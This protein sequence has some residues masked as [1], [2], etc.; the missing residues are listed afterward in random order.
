MAAAD[1]TALSLDQLLELTVVG[2]SKF[3]Q[4]QSEVAA[5]VSVI[6][7]QEIKAF[8]WRTIGEAL[9]SL[10]GI[11]T[12]YDRQYSYLGMR[13]FGLPGDYNTRVLVTVNGNRVNDA[14][15]DTGPSGRQFPVDID[16]IE[17]IEFIPGPGGAVY[18]Q[19][20]ML[21]VVNVVTRTGAGVD[22]AEL[23]A[24]HQQPQALSAGRATWGKLLDDGTDVLLS[25]SALHAHG[26]DRFLDFGASGVSG[27]AAGLDG[28]RSNQVLAH[29]AHGAW[30]LDLEHGDR[31]KGDPTGVYLSDPLVPGQ[32][33]QDR[34]EL[35][36]LQFQDS[37]AADTVHVAARLFEGQLR[38]SSI[39]SQAG[40]RFSYPASSDW[41]GAELRLRYTASARHKLMVGVEAQDNFNQDQAALDLGN[42]ANDIVIPGSGHRV[43][44]YVQDDWRISDTLAST[45]GLRMD[46]NNVTGA[47]LSPR[48][49]L[50]WQAAPATALK[51]LYGRAS[52]A[53]NNYECCY[54]GDGTGQVANPS[55]KGESIDTLELVVDH[56]VDRDLALRASIYR[57][58]ML[59]L[60]T[61]QPTD[62]SSA[63]S[64][65]QYQ[66]GAT[67][68]AQGVELSAD[69]TWASGARL[70]GS[71]SFQDAAS[72]DGSHLLNS[73]R[74]LGK[75]ELSGPLPLAGLR[76][77]Y[78]LRYDGPRLSR[79]GSTL[80]GYVLSNLTLSTEQLARGLEISFS[81]FNLFDEHYAQPAAAINWQNA[82][83][84]DGRSM[85]VQLVYR[86]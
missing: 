43:G 81:V 34:Y 52:R 50:I 4:K 19:N 76:A 46:R 26:Q 69:R 66:S 59:R 77:G 21:G 57:W 6:T 73:P 15:F 12:T 25:A 10:P 42:P 47:S 16:L 14:T 49:A 79:D 67:A 83:E 35:A 23:A 28:E 75:L 55:L 85:R 39:L 58:T 71:V 72:E 74:Q 80:G 31:Q 8:G 17:R 2:A 9:A 48:A 24:T 38:F 13:G 61:L 60:I 82:F 18:G 40:L 36:Q 32:Y 64:P 63:L 68:R 3:E 78:E 62:P 37:Y 1:L 65:S 27:V 30:S 86:L 29:A 51:T 70:R 84:Q 56:R 54:G 44:V 7:R 5:A 33:Q 11:Y 22:G 41:R 53:P 20:A 45:L